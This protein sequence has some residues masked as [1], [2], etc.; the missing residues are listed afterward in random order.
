M[1][2][3]LGIIMVTLIVASCHNA[4]TP[5]NTLNSNARNFVNNLVADS[6]YS[7]NFYVLKAPTDQGSGWVVVQDGFGDIYTINI[8]DSNLRY[9]YG[10]DLSY[11]DNQAIPATYIGGGYY[12]DIDGFIYEETSASAKDLEK[13][14]VAMENLNNAKFGKDISEKFGLSEERSLDVAKMVSSYKK[15]SKSRA[16]TES[17]ADSFMVK[18]LG[19]DAKTTM[20]A[21]N[22]LKEGNAEKFDSVL[23]QAAKV[24]GTSPETVRAIIS[25]TIK[26]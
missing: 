20:D 23:E 16:M 22:D 5:A 12:Q 18:L 25:E 3:L 9:S 2:K 4:T 6:G 15:L 11:F 19:T 10:S 8:Y 14:G 13:M 26:M 21:F 17:D 7:E 1:K 24:N